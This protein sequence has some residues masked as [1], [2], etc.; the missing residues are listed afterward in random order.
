[1]VRARR[2]LFSLSFLPP[3]VLCFTYSLSQSGEVFSPPPHVHNEGNVAKHRANHRKIRLRIHNACVNLSFAVRKVKVTFFL[4]IPVSSFL[5]GLRIAVIMQADLKVEAYRM[6]EDIKALQ[7]SCFQRC[8]NDMSTDQLSIVEAKCI[9]ACAAK[10]FQTR[11][12][13]QSVA[14]RGGQPGA[15]G[16]AGGLLRR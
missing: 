16:I 9:D 7:R 12:L 11:A 4:S 15:A 3:W 13:F 2:F 8:V 6:E 14:Q 5:D 1:M 10:Y